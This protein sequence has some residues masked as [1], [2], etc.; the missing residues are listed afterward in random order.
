MGTL[1]R[2]FQNKESPS[3]FMD[4]AAYSSRMESDV[5]LLQAF[6]SSCVT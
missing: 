5:A 1:A 6:P 2:T 3:F 4:Y